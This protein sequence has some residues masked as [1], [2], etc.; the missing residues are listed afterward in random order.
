MGCASSVHVYDSPSID[1]EGSCDKNEGHADI[2]KCVNVHK[3]EDV[4]RKISVLTMKSGNLKWNQKAPIGALEVLRLEVA[5]SQTSNASPSVNGAR[6]KVVDSP[7][8]F[9]KTANGL[10]VNSP[11]RM[12]IRNGNPFSSPHAHRNATPLVEQEEDSEDETKT[13]KLKT[14]NPEIKVG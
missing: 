7:A 11:S 6:A 3:D 5:D 2:C 1:K 9:R 10:M 4:R 12:R 14:N 8:P 13:T